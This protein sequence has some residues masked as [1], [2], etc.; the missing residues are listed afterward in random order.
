MHG[1]CNAW[2]EYNGIFPN[3]NPNPDPNPAPNPN[4]N[5][6]SKWELNLVLTL[7]QTLTSTRRTTG[8]HANTQQS[9][10]TPWQIE[11]AELF[12]DLIQAKSRVGVGWLELGLG[13]RG[14]VL[15][16]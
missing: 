4:P 15:L 7:S 12:E 3:P 13:V 2:E 9:K 1:C 5:P 8:G 10:M 6:N 14:G 11:L 16:T